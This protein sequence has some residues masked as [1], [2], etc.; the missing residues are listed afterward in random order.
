MIVEAM[1]L[2]KFKLDANAYLLDVDGLKSTFY[3]RLLSIL[4]PCGL[5]VLFLSVFFVI[6]CSCFCISITNFLILY[7]AVLPAGVS[8]FWHK[9]LPFG[10]CSLECYDSNNDNNN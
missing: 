7:L 5:T 1:E 3:T 10:V 9:A 8:G 4:V 2:Q 6:V